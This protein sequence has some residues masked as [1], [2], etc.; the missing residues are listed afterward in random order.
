MIRLGRSLTP[1]VFWD[2][3]RHHQSWTM[4]GLWHW[5]NEHWFTLF[6]VVVPFW[7]PKILKVSYDEKSE[8]SVVLRSSDL[9]E[10][11]KIK[12]PPNEKEKFFGAKYGFSFL[13]GVNVPTPGLS[14][15]YRFWAGPWKVAQ[16]S[17]AILLYVLEGY[18]PNLWKFQMIIKLSYIDDWDYFLTSERQL[19]HTLIKRHFVRLGTVDESAFN[20]ELVLQLEKTGTFDSRH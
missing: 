7:S 4:T 8:T 10:N 17:C 9:Y 16:Q 18:A 20:L 15:I 5:Y 1:L 13:V 12:L 19:W 6:Q 3:L 14:Y 2:G 11:Q